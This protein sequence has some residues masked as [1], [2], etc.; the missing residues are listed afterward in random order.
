MS[1]SYCGDRI[2]D[3]KLALFCDADF[4]GDKSD[5]RSTTGVV[6]YI[7]GPTTFFPIVSL[8]KK[9]GCVST[10][11]CGSEIVSLSVGLREALSVMDLW[12]VVF[13][14]FRGKIYSSKGGP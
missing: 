9:Q 5:S 6:V 11:T 3:L 7:A 14:K 8:S 10:S 1:S 4:V 13:E 2:D 12:E